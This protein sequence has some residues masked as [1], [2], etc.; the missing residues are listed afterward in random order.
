MNVQS[1]IALA[2]VRLNRLNQEKAV[3]ESRGDVQKLT[4]LE[5]EVIETQATLN[6]LRNI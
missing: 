6:Q 4:E 3:A 1:L 2:E 5:Q